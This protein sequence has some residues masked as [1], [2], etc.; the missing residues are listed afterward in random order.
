MVFAEA[1]QALGLLACTATQQSIIRFEKH[2]EVGDHKISEIALNINSQ[3]HR[4][5]RKPALNNA[6]PVIIAG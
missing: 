2:K 6:V 1:V 5:Q 4:F 3:D